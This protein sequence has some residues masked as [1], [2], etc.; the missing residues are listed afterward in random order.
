MYKLV[1]SNGIILQDS[2]TYTDYFVTLINNY[3]KSDYSINDFNRIVKYFTSISLY[4]FHLTRLMEE[5]IVDIVK[6]GLKVSS[7][8]MMKNKIK[9]I[10]KKQLISK[11]EYEK[12]GKIK[13][14]EY[15]NADDAGS[16]FF[17]SYNPNQYGNEG[18][19]LDYGGEQFF[20]MLEQCKEIDG[21][22]IKDKLR[23]KSI[24]C[25]IVFKIPPKSL[26]KK[27]YNKT[28]LKQFINDLC[29]LYSK[30]ALV[31]LIV[32]KKLKS[33][34]KVYKIIKF[35]EIDIKRIEST[36]KYIEIINDTN[37]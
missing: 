19:L 10:Y 12:L 16:L 4:C 29:D 24:P 25:M 32:D 18:L 5:E 36:G 13:F 14:Y 34:V 31:N 11:V 9:L 20:T 33:N 3:I 28:T 2:N 17:I 6:N 27:L 1:L 21:E 7:Q 23:E 37:Q 30:N 8:K 15:H 22:L 35:D 26:V